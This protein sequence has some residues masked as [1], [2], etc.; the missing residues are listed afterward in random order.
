MAAAGGSVLASQDPARKERVRVV[1]IQPQYTAG[2]LSVGIR[3]EYAAL[4][5]CPEGSVFPAVFLRQ[6]AVACSVP[7]TLR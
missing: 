5:T 1:A 4:W 7:P 6:L 3:R 2:Q